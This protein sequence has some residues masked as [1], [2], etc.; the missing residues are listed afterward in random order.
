MNISV[1]GLAT[2]IG[3]FFGRCD[4]IQIDA[5]ERAVSHE[6]GTHRGIDAVV[7]P[8]VVGLFC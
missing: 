4:F 2:Q 7:Q 1:N 8:L 6:F 5:S 3:V